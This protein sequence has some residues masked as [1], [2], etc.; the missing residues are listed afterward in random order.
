MGQ[1]AVFC[2][3]SHVVVMDHDV[4]SLNLA[5][6]PAGVAPD[7]VHIM[8][9]GT[10]SGL[11][12]RGPYTLKNAEAVIAA[13]MSR[14][15]VPFDEN[16]ATE[17]AAVIG[18]PAP[19]RGW[20]DRMEVRADG[21]WAHVEWTPAGRAILEGK[22]YRWISPVFNHTKSGDATLIKS[23]A[24]TNNPNLLE[25]LT[26]M[27]TRLADA[28][29]GKMEPQHFAVPE[30]QMLPIE[31]A[32]HVKLAW[33]MLGRTEG[34][35][36]AEKTEA[37]KRILA[38]AK[39]LGVSTSFWAAHTQKEDQMDKVAIC[40]ALGLPEATDDAAVLTALQTAQGLSTA[41]QT[42][43]ARVGELEAELK[44]V[45]TTFVPL[46]TVTAMQTQIAGMVA[47][48]KRAKAEAFVD[49]A[50]KAGKPILPEMRD[51]YI[52]RHVADSGETELF[53]NSLP[54]LNAAGPGTFSKPKPGDDPDGLAEMTAEDKAVCAKMGLDPKKFMASKR[55]QRGAA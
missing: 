12:G 55:K 29:R 20:I 2:T 8:P 46:E 37:K 24:L 15:A 49:A 36:D 54:S 13:S 1:R 34:L 40:T 33:D 45:K 19:A 50:I 5:L 41:L 6:P 9:A 47:D 32:E 11:D 4:S 10:F 38:R 3:P 52:A 16:H 25:H 30:K 43:T 26:A 21:I 51:K 48:N 39:E 44:T 27:Q 42:A 53:V 18:G 14:G 31:D 22:E 23:V 17:T 7:W 28:Q 35:T